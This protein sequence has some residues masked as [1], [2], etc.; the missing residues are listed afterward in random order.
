[1]ATVSLNCNRRAILLVHKWP[2]NQWPGGE[3]LT[4]RLPI[5]NSNLHSIPWTAVWF[6]WRKYHRKFIS[7]HTSQPAYE[8]KQVINT[9]TLDTRSNFI[10]FYL[11]KIQITIVMGARTSLCTRRMLYSRISPPGCHNN[12]YCILQN[13]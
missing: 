12:C 2:G 6:P 10:H 3:S 4:S 13:N 9:T 8:C 7:K 1:M 11:D 5:F